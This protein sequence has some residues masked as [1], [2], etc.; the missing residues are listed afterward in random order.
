MITTPPTTAEKKRMI[1]MCS[2]A[3]GLY[4]KVL[5]AIP[6]NFPKGNEEK[7]LDL[8]RRAYVNTLDYCLGRGVDY[9]GYLS[10]KQSTD[11]TEQ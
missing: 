7:L 1:E 5:E 8:T 9:V 3:H 10:R 2:L 11:T 4:A 6:Q